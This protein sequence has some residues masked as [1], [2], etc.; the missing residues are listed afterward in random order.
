V[1]KILLVE[2]ED[3]LREL[4]G[5]RL[6][7]NGYEVATAADGYDAIHK[8][9]AVH[10]DLVI[11]DLM[12]PKMDGYT[13]CRLLRF[14][15]YGEIPIIIFSARSGPDDVRRGIEMGASAY[16]TKPFEPAVLL[17]KIEELL[18][19]KEAKAAGQPAAPQLAAGAAK[20]S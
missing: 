11:L 17:G 10:P 9:R 6:Q 1:A 19:A 3:N 2:D 18:K 16:V 5:G 7:Q 13:V 12:I 8:A 20:P 15:G 14:S 4:V